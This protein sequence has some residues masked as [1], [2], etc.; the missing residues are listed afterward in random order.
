MCKV[1]RGLFELGL[2]H[3]GKQEYSL[4]AKASPCQIFYF[5]GEEQTCEGL[6][7]RIVLSAL[8][9]V[10]AALELLFLLSSRHWALQLCKVTSR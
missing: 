5:G 9:F 8:L 1:G 10:S 4:Y 7:M 3:R 2:A 6:C